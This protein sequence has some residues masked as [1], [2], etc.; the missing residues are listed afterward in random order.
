MDRRLDVN[1]GFKLQARNLAESIDD[2]LDREKGITNDLLPILWRVNR[3]GN[4]MADDQSYKRARDAVFKAVFRNCNTNRQVYLPNPTR[5]RHLSDTTVHK[6]KIDGTPTNKRNIKRIAGARVFVKVL[7][8]FPIA[9]L[10]LTMVDENGS[11]FPN[12]IVV[13]YVPDYDLPRLRTEATMK[14]DNAG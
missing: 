5:E 7:A 13:T 11:V 6:R 9:Q 1:A 10:T 8:G 14:C 3:L 4:P 12:S 2:L